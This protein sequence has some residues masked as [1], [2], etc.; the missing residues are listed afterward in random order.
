[1]NRLRG[2]GS[3]LI[4]VATLA[5]VPVGLLAWGHLPDPSD[6]APLLADPAT[7][8]LV[9]VTVGGWVGWAA[10]AM[11]V[12]LETASMATRGRVR[13]RLLPSLQGVV[14]ALLATVAGL[15]LTRSVALEQAPRVTT[16]AVTEASHTST[17]HETKPKLSQRASHLVSDSDDLWTLAETRLGDGMRWREIAELNPGLAADPMQR[18]RA[19]TRIALPVVTPVETSAVT[20]G[21]VTVVRGDTLSGLAQSHLGDST[22]WPDIADV[23]S[24]LVKDPD[25]IEVGWVLSMPT[26]AAPDPAPAPIPEATTA[27][28]QRPPTPPPTQA[29]PT[30]LPE[31]ATPVEPSGDASASPS[32]DAVTPT[33]AT[34]PGNLAP[35]LDVD[36]TLPLLGTLSAGLAGAVLTGLGVRR[37][38]ARWG[39]PLGRRALVPNQA[40]ARFETALGLRSA[41]RADAGF[42]RACRHIGRHCHESGQPL[43][44]LR[45]A[46]LEDGVVVFHWESCEAG[47]PPGFTA[48]KGTWRVSAGDL[49]ELTH[50]HP[51]P[52]TITLGTDAGRAVMV[53]LEALGILQL[54]SEAAD[55]PLDALSALAL[56][57]CNHPWAGELELVVV[58]T[59]P[60]FLMVASREPIRSCTLVDEAIDLL[61]AAASSRRAAAPLGGIAE[62]RV[63]PDRVDAWR[64]IVFA[65]LDPL[66]RTQSRR[67]HDALAGGAPGVAV[68]CLGTGA[69]QWHL[70]PSDPLTGTLDGTLTLHAQAVPP[71]TRTAIGTLFRVADSVETTPAPWWFEETD[72]VVPLR[73]RG[74]ER[75]P[76]SAH[77]TLHLIGP[78][79][80]RGAKGQPPE[81]ARRQCEEYCGW[82][83]EHPNRTATSMDDALL[84]ASGTRRSNMSRLR[85]WLGNS[86]DGE[87]YLPDAYSGRIALHPGV[88][89]DWQRLEILLG[90]GANRLDEETLVKALEMVR[91]A[92]LADAAPGQWFWAESLRI[93]ISSAIRDTGAVLCRHALHHGDID[94]AR[95]A[96]GRAL[97]AAPEDEE[98]LRWRIRTEHRAGNRAEVERIVLQLNRHARSLGVDLDEESVLLCQEVMEGRL[99]ARG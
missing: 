87:P 88:S 55:L 47:A 90:P 32:S 43:P 53:D 85:A 25:H 51:F 38:L 33:S 84:V 30:P 57:L 67:L 27:P 8:L 35:T 59:E 74:P 37:D 45:R 10:F 89:S 20:A 54:S 29:R 81:R 66:T 2:L 12:V 92:P 40:S 68:L 82:L 58:G 6:L 15:G 65:F 94:L 86:P 75:G 70:S 19:G 18:L 22:R 5:G 60:Q 83:L 48:Q 14:A 52:A 71:H 4:I 26:V 24:G 76:E 50:P 69:H 36:L 7:L 91:G 13:I 72:N 23:N 62:A 73:V 41:V 93:D 98:L 46:V 64:P 97:L 79:E 78:I 99:R 17:P 44:V 56:E 9:L 11:S 80:L 96:A 3:L 34:S 95:W 49:E 63:D 16:V 28:D 39:R 21:G 61:I 1:M 31:A 77:P 42:E